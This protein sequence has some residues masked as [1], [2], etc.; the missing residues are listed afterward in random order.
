MKI[1]IMGLGYVGATTG[2]VFADLGWNVIGYDPNEERLSALARGSLPFY[3][4]G[5]SDKLKEHGETGRI[6]F[7]SDLPEAISECETIFICVGTPAKEDGSADLQ[8]IEQAA[9][10]I[11]RY[12]QDDKLV[13]IK[14]TVPVGT[15]EK[16]AAWIA[17]AQPS[18]ISF[19]V[20]SNPEFLREG[21][22][23]YD[24][25]HPERIVIGSHQPEAARKVQR[26]YKGISC[27]MVLCSPRTAELIKYASNAYL[28]AKISYIN[29]LA[30]LCDRIG[31]DVR[32]VAAGMGLDSRIGKRFLHAGI[33]FGGSCFPKDI[34]AL[35][36]EAHRQGTKLTIV[37]SAHEVNRTQVRY[38]IDLW[39]PV[40]EG[41][42][43]KT[44][45]VLGLSFK[46]DTDDLRESPSLA[47][48]DELLQ[49][50]AYVQAHDPLARLP[51][52]Y[53]R[54]R[55]KQFETM[56]GALY[57][58][59]AVIIATDWDQYADA[60]WAR[61]KAKM[62]RPIIF[63][64]KNMLSGRRLRELGYEY[65]GI[66]TNAESI[67]PYVPCSEHHPERMDSKV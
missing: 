55:V 44:V 65:W 15:N 12:M 60:D 40:I 18:K 48:I 33:G 17:G 50:H 8:Y 49:R 11:G 41:F 21:R 7:T 63:D 39:E 22:A 25:F 16:V 23:L 59:D 6:R 19:D 3:E 32:D 34:Q 35:I 9:V 4:P 24:A 62:H 37:E 56:E 36:H 43:N 13:V 20:V 67:G 28:A 52:V 45:A 66:G 61:L 46:K 57:D 42:E 26:L 5:L 14:S 53:P 10:S 27:P 1:L 47:I 30:R 54:T 38:A 58:A 31:V 29:E 64:G 2:L 51:E